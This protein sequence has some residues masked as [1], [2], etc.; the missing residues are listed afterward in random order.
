VEDAPGNG[1]HGTAV[2]DLAYAEGRPNNGMA[3]GSDR[4]DDVVEQGQFDVSGA[5]ILPA[6]FRRRAGM[7]QGSDEF[8]RKRAAPMRGT[9]PSCIP[10]RHENAADRLLANGPPRPWNPPARRERP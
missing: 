2:A 10:Q 5:T 3:T 6:E 4:T 7:S 9:Q 8:M 1:L